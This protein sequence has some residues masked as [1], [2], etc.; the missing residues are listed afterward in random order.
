MTYWMLNLVFLVI[1]ALVALAA[2]LS[3]RSPSWRAIGLSGI[4]LVIMTAIFDNVI[5]GI[6]L[7]DYDPDRFAGIRIGLAPLEDFAYTI[8]ALFLLPSLWRLLDRRPRA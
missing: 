2:V 1:V 3:K 7:V 4:V 5:I 6:G 8:A